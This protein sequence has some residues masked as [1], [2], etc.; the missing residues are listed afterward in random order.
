MHGSGDE[1]GYIELAN[2]SALGG[3][4]FRLALPVSRA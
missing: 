4:R 2:D 1:R 3:S